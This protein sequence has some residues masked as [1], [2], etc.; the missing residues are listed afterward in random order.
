MYLDDR[1]SFDPVLNRSAFTIPLTG[2][3]VK[4]IRNT[5]VNRSIELRM[6]W[7]GLVGVYIFYFFHAMTLE[8]R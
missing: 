5:S 4:K 6:G 1:I 7:T 8:I 3:Y 2:Q